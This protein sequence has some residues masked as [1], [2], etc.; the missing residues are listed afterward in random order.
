MGYCITCQQ[1]VTEGRFCP[2]CGKQTV[3][4]VFEQ[5]QLADTPATSTGQLAM[6]SHLIPI[7]GGVLALVTFISIFLLWIPGLVIRGLTNATE[8]D[9]RHATESLNFQLTMLLITFAVIVMG[10]LTIF[11]GFLVLIPVWIV[12]EV[13]AL[14]FTIQATVAASKLQEYRYPMAIRFVK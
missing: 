14:I 12:I 13:V 1:N 3:D 2:T 8:F 7:I 9:R 6:W 10:V 4:V 11:I 5:Q